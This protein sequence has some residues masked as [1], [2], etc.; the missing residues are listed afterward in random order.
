MLPLIMI[1]LVKDL[2]D[3]VNSE[4]KDAYLH[5]FKSAALEDKIKVIEKDNN[6]KA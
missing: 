3:L 6:I 1:G 2:K 5:G 4:M